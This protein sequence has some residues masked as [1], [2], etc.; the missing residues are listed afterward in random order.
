[1]KTFDMKRFWNATVWLAMNRLHAMMKTSIG[2]AV[3]FFFLFLWVGTTEPVARMS[4]YAVN[5]SMLAV[6]N[7]VQVAVLMFAGSW[8][9]TDMLSVQG[10]IRALM[11][12]ASNFE[13][14]VSRCVFALVSSFAVVFVAT[15]AADACQMLFRLVTGGH[16][17]VMS[18]MCIKSLF[19]MLS[20]DF[21][22]DTFAA[23]LLLS[24]LFFVVH[25]FYVLGG[26]FFRR[27]QWILTTL[28]SFVAFN[29]FG[30]LISAFFMG[31]DFNFLY[32][33]GEWMDTMTRTYGD[34]VSFVALG[35]FDLFLLLLVV[36]FY[37]MAYKLFCRI[38]LKNNKWTNL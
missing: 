16:V 31:L 17:A 32:S 8:I 7:T 11:L 22:A 24:L 5:S 19:M 2:L 25:S 20:Y 23:N 13:K 26:V 27:N 3:F 28:V 36:A 6:F 21:G 15:L 37:W 4:L 9:T 33:V 30:G 38:Q 1:M 10:R 34:V 14:F 18:W 29:V 12:P 35:V